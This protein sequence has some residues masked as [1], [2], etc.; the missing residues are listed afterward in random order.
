MRNAGIDVEKA[1]KTRQLEVALRRCMLCPNTDTCSGWLA[2]G[3]AGRL[4][5]FCPNAGYLRKLERS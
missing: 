4:E 2:S 5:D 3:A 1:M